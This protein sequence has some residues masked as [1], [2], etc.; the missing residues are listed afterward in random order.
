MARYDYLNNYLNSNMNNYKSGGMFTSYNVGGT[1][2]ESPHG[3]IPLGDDALVEQGETSVNLDQEGIPTDKGTGSKYIFSD[4]QVWTPEDL[5]AA[6]L[7]S[8]RGPVTAGQYM[9]KL[10]DKFKDRAGSKADKETLNTFTQ[11]ATQLAEQKRMQQ[12]QIEQAMQM[13]AQQVAPENT[14]VPEGMEQ[15]YGGGFQNDFGMMSADAEVAE[16][17]E[18]SLT[19]AGSYVKAAGSAFNLYNMAKEGNTSRNKGK[20]IGTGAAEGAMAGAAFG[21]WGA[22]AGGIIGAGAGYFGSNKAEKNYWEQTDKAIVQANS[23]MPNSSAW[24]AMGGYITSK[25]SKYANGGPIKPKWM[26]DP[27]LYNP[28][29]QQDK[30]ENALKY[31]DDWQKSPMYNKM[32]S[33]SSK[34]TEEFNK[35]KQ[36]REYGLYQTRFNPITENLK[37]GALG[38]ANPEGSINISPLG[39]FR[40]S[41]Y[42]HET[43]HT[44]DTVRGED[45]K[46]NTYIPENDLALMKKL[47]LKGAVKDD[48]TKYISEPTEVRARI[49][50][51][52]ANSKDRNI[53]DP[54]NEKMTRKQYKKAS[55]HGDIAPVLD[56]ESI[57]GKRKTLKL[58]NSISDV[59]KNGKN[60]AAN[61]GYVKKFLYGG[62]DEEEGTL[63][64]KGLTSDLA[65]AYQTGNPANAIYGDSTDVT[66]NVQSA[67]GLQPGKW[68]PKSQTA[69]GNWTMQNNPEAYNDPKFVNK[70]NKLG[71]KN[72]FSKTYP[73]NITNKTFEQMGLT[74]GGRQ[75]LKPV[76]SYLKPKT[77]NDILPKLPTNRQEIPVQT[78]TVPNFTQRL[79]IRGYNAGK[80]LVQGVATAGEGAANWLDEN[81][82]DIA[83]AYPIISNMIERGNIRKPTGTYSARL[84]DS[85]NVPQVD[86]ARA[87]RDI[88]SAYNNR[89]RAIGQMGGSQ[90]QQRVGNLALG[91]QQNQAISQTQEGLE[92]VRIQRAMQEQQYKNQIAQYNASKSDY[93][94]EVYDKDLG[95]Y[96]TQ[97]SKFT[98]QIGNDIGQIGL[99]QDRM[100]QVANMYGYDRKGKYLVNKKT[101]K[102]A[103]PEEISKI[104][105]IS[106]LAE[107]KKTAVSAYGGFI[108]KGRYGK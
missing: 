101:G 42:D 26:S 64:N 37:N 20:A 12:E 82:N 14:E 79:G 77:V 80:D 83:R 91:T 88:N 52:R 60:V 33:N 92:S 7:P 31:Q 30:A 43:S 15:F 11:R 36:G 28:E 29:I 72:A 4:R 3:G 23:G 74:P 54:Y 62:E 68:G 56:L 90:A 50:S 51:V 105:E 1:H 97:R 22:L 73:E 53:Y 45:G 2:E 19:G 61:G 10:N 44:T 35:I 66:S 48:Y 84:N 58:I 107:E 81:K 104:A 102:V 9:A 27:N 71:V 78:T 49:N 8:H 69:F 21:P 57:Y 98:A 76:E 13:N 25:P 38:E 17:T 75:Y 94:K 39:R 24:S 86:E 106:K 18:G 103:T 95:N 67:I 65:R 5:K 89:Y 70:V 99:E 87:M 34:D 55:S 41:I 16:P 100:D 40:Q 6:G 93:D 96:E 59:S 32:L 63:T 85:Y 47:Q 46:I 108:T